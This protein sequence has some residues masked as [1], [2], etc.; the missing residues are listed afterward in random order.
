MDLQVKNRTVL[1]KKVRGLRR[2]DII[3]AEVF[4]RD[5]QNRHLSVPKKDFV[6]IYKKAGEHTII[7]LIDEQGKKIPALISDVIL[8]PLSDEIL[9]IDFHQIRMDEKIQTKIPIEFKGEAPAIKGGFVLVNVLDELEIEALPS[10]IP[11]NFEVDLTALENPG[12]SIAVRD[13][14]IPRGV[15]ILTPGE[16]VIV[17]VTEK[18]KE[19][20]EAAPPPAPTA[21]AAEAQTAPAA[22]TT[23]SRG[24]DQEISPPH[25]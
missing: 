1:G 15:K 11:H 25:Q 8:H 2:T 12:Q 10:D 13:L 23:P 14:E 22:Q 18:A 19:E 17:T 16:T 20:V 4:G 9:T 24:N 7:N 5:L 3:P 21:G 6:K